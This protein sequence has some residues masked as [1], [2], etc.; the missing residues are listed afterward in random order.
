MWTS[1]NW[2]IYSNYDECQQQCEGIGLHSSEYG[3][4][5]TTFS[6]ERWSS[7][8]E[9]DSLEITINHNYRSR[10]D[11]PIRFENEGNPATLQTF[12][13]KT[14]NWDAK[15]QERIK[16]QLIALSKE[17]VMIIS[18][19]FIHRFLSSFQFLIEFFRR[20]KLLSR[21]FSFFEQFQS[22]KLFHENHIS[23]FHSM[24][25][26]PPQILIWELTTLE[27]QIWK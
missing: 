13:V 24:S 15:S 5:R 6:I 18:I 10:L 22:W 11:S 2:E 20:F 23:N 17:L 12:A 4:R 8:S 7:C 16:S 26:I 3:K 27:N 21:E 19:I 14:R 9:R 25:T 1:T